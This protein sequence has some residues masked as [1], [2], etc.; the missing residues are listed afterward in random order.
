MP[1]YKAVIFR[2]AVQNRGTISGFR[3]KQ[4]QVQVMAR[5]LASS[6]ITCTKITW[7]LLQQPPF[8]GALTVGQAR[9]KTLSKEENTTSFDKSVA[10]VLKQSPFCRWGN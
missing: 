5:L 3:G 6:V 1:G 2:E 4:I 8:S 10:E 7:S 9:C